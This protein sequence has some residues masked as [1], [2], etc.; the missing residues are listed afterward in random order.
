MNLLKR[1]ITVAAAVLLALPLMAGDV[2]GKVHLKGQLIG[3]G[4]RTV[5]MAYDGASSMLGS[6]RNITLHLDAEGRFDTVIA[7]KSP[8]YYT[9]SR[10]T[11]YLSPGDDLTVSI[12]SR[13]QDAT[14]AGRGAEANEYMKHRLFPHAGSY[15]NG[16]MNVKD[17]FAATRHLIDSLADLRRGQLAALPHVS[18]EFKQLE[19]ARID[20]DVLN[21]YAYYPT[22]A[23]IQAQI[24][25]E[26]RLAIRRQQ[27]D[28][29]YT[30]LA[31][32][33]RP[34]VERINREQLLDVAVVR[35]V[36]ATLQTDKGMKSWREGITF[37]PRACELIQCA[38]HVDKLRGHLDAN[39]LAEAGEY[40]RQVS[41]KEFADELL[42]RV[43]QAGKLLKGPA[44]DFALT[45]AEGDTLRL[46]HFKGKVIYLDF[47]ATWCGPCVKE[48]PHFEALAQA[49]AGRD[50]VFI[51]ISID[52]N[53][54]TWSNYLASHPK[55][56]AQYHSVDNAIR[57]GWA[58][59]YIPRFVLIDK[60]FNI[61]E[62]YAP[63]PSEEKAKAMLED[64]LK[65]K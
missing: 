37:T 35:S 55:K 28:S 48:S 17:D 56:L 11:L 58:I 23:N 21:S 18:E 34:L 39:A 5:T 22:Y 57:S 50:V 15:M 16:G 65:E 59:Q 2:A 1:N 54:K 36:L 19:G 38:M 49:F 8:A 45:N 14:F 3:M 51:P 43:E 30:A 32:D 61:V 10:N 44:I 29:F 24:R 60:D 9:I 42:L 12:T 64:L 4:T 7:I 41:D 20:A 25:K 27:V 31:D 46:S 53:R 62:A 52:N 47:W 6:S 26:P 33:M 13:N 40:A 63:R